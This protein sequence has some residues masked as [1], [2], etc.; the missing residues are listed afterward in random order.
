MYVSCAWQFI[1]DDSAQ[2]LHLT[3]RNHCNVSPRA[4]RSPWGPQSVRTRTATMNRFYSYGLRRVSACAA[5]PVARFPSGVHVRAPLRSAL[6]LEHTQPWRTWS[7]SS[8][9]AA[10]TCRST[11]P[12]APGVRCGVELV[13]ETLPRE[14]CVHLTIHD[15]ACSVLKLLVKVRVEARRALLALQLCPE[16]VGIL[17]QCDALSR[18]RRKAGTARRRSAHAGKCPGPMLAATCS[19]RPRFGSRHA[20]RWEW[21]ARGLW[22]S[23]GTASCSECRGISCHTSGATLGSAAQT[24]WGPS[25]SSC[26]RS[27]T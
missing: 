4:A 10:G 23:P 1:V 8:S 11:V 16:R 25:T 26:R 17:D 19:T 18:G 2:S 12:L 24:A 20:V 5:P 13:E 21:A 27:R 3:L 6:R 14:V 7:A 9:M 22:L 15:V